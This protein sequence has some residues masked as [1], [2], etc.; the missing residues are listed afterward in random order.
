MLSPKLDQ[1]EA[2]AVGTRHFIDCILNDTKPLTDG[3]AGVNVVRILEA[4]AVSIKDRG[5]QVE[6]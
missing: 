1:E 5:R 3:A 2:L 4:S 6:L